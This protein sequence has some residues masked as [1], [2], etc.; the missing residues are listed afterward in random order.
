M[1]L[2]KIQPWEMG[3]RLKCDLSCC[4]AFYFDGKLGYVGQ[5]IS[6]K[7]RLRSYRIRYS[8]SVIVTPWGKF[9]RVILK[10]RPSV[11]F[12]DWAMVELRL[13]KRLQPPYN[14]SGSIRPRIN[15][16]QRG[17]FW[18]EESLHNA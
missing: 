7:R 14:C 11:K 16:G 13:I 17:I 6:L 1:G 8:G 3:G 15:L 9:S 12:G 18:Q 2:W 10:V 5:T 4:Y